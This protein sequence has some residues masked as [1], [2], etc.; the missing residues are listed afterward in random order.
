MRYVLFEVMKGSGRKEPAASEA[1]TRLN[2]RKSI[3]VN[4]PLKAGHVISAG[5]ISV[6][7]PGTGVEP[8]HLETLAGRRLVKDLDA[9]AVLQWSDLA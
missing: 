3:V 1:T 4:R 7:R 6:K 8:K 9:D 2:N 5:D